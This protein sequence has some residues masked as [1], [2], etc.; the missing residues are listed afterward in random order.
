[1]NFC[2][3]RSHFSLLLQAVSKGIINSLSHKVTY[4]YMMIDTS[5][6]GFSTNKVKCHWNIFY[7]SIINF[8]KRGLCLGFSNTSYVGSLYR[9]RKTV[10]VKAKL[11]ISIGK[12]EAFK[13]RKYE[14]K[15]CKWVHSKHGIGW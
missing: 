5:V 15:I 14:N 7:H 2:Y 9:F 12:K 8:V 1:M 4:A 10:V 6:N 13:R 11:D 3:L